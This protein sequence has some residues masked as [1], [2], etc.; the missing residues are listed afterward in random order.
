MMAQYQ[1]PRIIVKKNLIIFENAE[2][3]LPIRKNIVAQHGLLYL[4]STVMKR[5]LGFTVRQ[6]QQWI[7]IDKNNRGDDIVPRGYLQEQI[8]LDF[9]NDAALTWFQLKYL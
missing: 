2:L 4:I 9:Y 3:W 8:H 7:T 1:T 5:E 6:H